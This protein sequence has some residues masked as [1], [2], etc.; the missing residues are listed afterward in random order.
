MGVR[1]REASM[2]DWVNERAREM[3]EIIVEIEKI[4]G[5]FT[6]SQLCWRPQE[7]E[8]STAQIIEH[9]LLTDAPCVEAFSRLLATAPRGEA[10]WRPTIIG[11]LITK[12]VE[13]Q[14]RRK[15]RAGKGFLPA[16][17]PAA[18]VI[19]EYVA[20]RKRLL[21]LVMRSADVDLNRVKTTYPIRTP[22]RYNLGDAF[23]ILTRHTQRHLQQIKRIRLHPEFPTRE[24][25]LGV[26]HTA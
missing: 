8:W 24:V 25:V 20:I 22:L 6:Y 18:G 11:R 10:R 19:A 16:P 9:L 1:I 23:T 2:T 7:G 21:E 5:E 3:R 15:T 14:T 17:Q 4:E 12:A 26:P 13:P